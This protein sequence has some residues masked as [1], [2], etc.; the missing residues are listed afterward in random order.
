M[1]VARTLAAAL[2]TAVSALALAACASNSEFPPGPTNAPDAGTDRPFGNTC[3]VTSQCTAHNHL[4]VREQNANEGECL[5][6]TR[7]GLCTPTGDA[8]SPE[9]PNCFPG[10]RCQPVPRTQSDLGGMCSFTG[11]P[12]AVFA[13]T[14]AQ[15]IALLEPSPFNTYAERQ[16]ISFRWTPPA[17][18]TADTA[19]VAVLMRRVPQREP[20]YNRLSNPQDIVWIWSSTAPGGAAPGMVS[21]RAGHQGVLRDGSLGPSY[22]A[23][24]LPAG[25]YWWMTYT[26]RDGGVRA[27]SD[28]FSFRVGPD[29]AE[30]T[31]TNVGECVARVPGESADLVACVYGRC[32]RRCASDLDCPGAGRRC[33]VATTLEPP[34][35][36]TVDREIPHGAFCAQR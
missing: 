7:G 28:V 21:L 12:G 23:D 13:V 16:A 3:G 29:V 34:A 35:G 27:T 36:G 5:P 26:I 14:G 25:R 20:N 17:D 19:A 6:P 8:T 4:C 2:L 9:L 32:R 24:T 1:T 31:C 18:A 15:K 10:A 30:E 22:A 33:D 11:T